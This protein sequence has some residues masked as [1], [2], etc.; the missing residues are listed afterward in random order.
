M[1]RVVSVDSTKCIYS[2]GVLWKT[3]LPVS[4]SSSLASLLL[5]WLFPQS[6]V[7][8]GDGH[9]QND[10]DD[11]DYDDHLD[12]HADDV[13]WKFIDTNCRLPGPLLLVDSQTFLPDCNSR[14]PNQDLCPNLIVSNRIREIDKTNRFIFFTQVEI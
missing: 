10:H 14:L 7:D 6:F 3:C 9:D 8:D 1:R 2:T 4:S 12:D 5:V 11:Q 13:V